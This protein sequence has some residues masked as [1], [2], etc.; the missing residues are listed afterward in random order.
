MSYDPFRYSYQFSFQTP[1]FMGQL[2][3]QCG[4]IVMRSTVLST[5]EGTH[6]VSFETN[7]RLQRDEDG[8][9]VVGDIA[10]DDTNKSACVVYG[11]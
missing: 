4:A 5:H 11:R 8:F 9:L 10:I 7:Y 6:T 1:A 3:S 2:L